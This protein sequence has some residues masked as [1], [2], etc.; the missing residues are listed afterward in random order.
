MRRFVSSRAR[1]Q[2]LFAF[3]WLL[4]AFLLLAFYYRQVWRLFALKPR[5]WVRDNYSLFVFFQSG[6]DFLT[7]GWS[8]WYLPNMVEAFVRIV[9]A[10]FGFVL[11]MLSAQVLGIGLRRLLRWSPDN[12]REALLYQTGIGIGALSYLF[13]SLA[14]LGVYNPTSVRITI[15]LLLIAGGVWFRKSLRY[16]ARQKVKVSYFYATNDPADR[17]WQLIALLAIL[18]ALVG[19]AA[20]EIEYDAL[21]YHLWLPKI[22]LEQGGPVDVITEF[23]SLYPLTWELIYGLGISLGGAITAKL[24]H[25]ACLLLVGLLVYQLTY[26]FVPRGSPWLAVALFATIPTVLWEAT[27]AYVDL[28]L[29][30]YTGLAI[31]ALF[32]Y[33]EGRSRQWFILAVLNL[34][35]AL[36]TKHLGLFVL[37]LTTTGLA[38]GLWL[39][40]R[41]LRWALVPAVLLGLGS[42]LLPL[43]WYLR[44]WLASGNPVFPDLYGIFGASPP[45]RWNGISEQGWRHFVAQFGRPR[46]AFNQLTLL[47]DMTVHAARYGGTLGPMFL[48]L[49]PGL[50]LLPRRSRVIPWLVA[51]VLVYIG[52]WSS[53]L[54]GPQMRFLI[55]LTPLLAVLA[56]E[57]SDRLTL[58]LQSSLAWWAKGA[59]QAG[60]AALLLLNLPPF[61]S[62]HEGD[63]I[64]WDNWLTHVIHQVPISVVL[65]KESEEIYLTQAVPSYAAWRY[66]NTNL[67]TKAFILTFSGG[68]HFY[69][70]R[71]RLWSDSTMA[72]PATWGSSRGHEQRVLQTLHSLG[73]SHILFDKQQLESG[74]L[75]NLA[76]VQPA[77][78]ANWYEK[79]YE[80]DRFVLFRLLEEQNSSTRKGISF[81][82]NS[83]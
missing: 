33:V 64:V 1:C 14:L 29:A 5:A 47:W 57:A 62:V 50:G 28:G 7:S 39:Q 12:W 51:F 60:L 77:L 37:A 80:D 10:T 46:T 73:V 19:A 52:L 54:N 13:L 71:K 81:N 34:G 48:L 23:I 6:R 30:F 49:L 69:S 25:F 74:Q 21:W 53:P 35:L 70:D 9:M 63:R 36:A 61:T 32:R 68:D 3:I 11:I 42:L 17:V 59:F 40:D 41:S 44:S 2:R 66:I 82:D 38:L 76:I 58:L 45:E 4:W 67:P 83:Q 79:V 75:D 27:T 26:R 65:G 8:S 78:M 22:W 43:F 31:Y 16:V 72:Y 56:A 20:P 15:I 55:P 18:I 24:L